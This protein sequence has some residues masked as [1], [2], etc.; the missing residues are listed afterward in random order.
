MA[1][2]RSSGFLVA[3]LL[4]LPGP[5]RGDDYVITRVHTGLRIMTGGVVRVSGSGEFQTSPPADTFDASAGI[6]VDL[7][8]GSTTWSHSWVAAECTTGRNG[9][10]RCRS[11]D[12]LASAVFRPIASP[13]DAW[14][15]RVTFRTSGTVT[16]AAGTLRVIHGAGVTRVGTAAVCSFHNPIFKCS[17]P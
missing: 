17:A 8:G 5:A 12:R 2:R 13:P 14:R 11:A 10:I 7:E 1:I 3:I 16:G 15:L 6:T 4:C 9:A